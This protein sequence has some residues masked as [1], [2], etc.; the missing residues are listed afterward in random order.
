MA[1]LPA[2]R[3]NE[4]DTD[5]I[6]RR[7]AELATGSEE[8]LARRGLT[9]HEM[10]A[11]AREAGLDPELVRQAARDV[12]TRHAQASAPWAGAPRR[13][14]L[15]EEFEGELT[16]EVWESMVGEIQRTLG[17]MGFASRVGRTRSWIVSQTGA[18]GPASRALSVT[19]TPQRGKTIV[20]IEENLSQLAGALFGG[21]VGGFGGGTVGLWTGVG[22]GVLHSPAAAVALV[23]A[24]LIGSY[25]AARHFFVRTYRKR[26]EELSDLL[27]R[28]GTA[29][30]LDG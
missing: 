11:L 8:E 29:R 5:A 14:V 2:R 9:I 25:T 24:S 12:S 30:P 13:I 7:T 20:R 1:D 17:G 28:L 10:E 21:V 26:S 4:T 23:I 6:L 27:T 15:E 16:E 18:R 3:F 22:M 19:A